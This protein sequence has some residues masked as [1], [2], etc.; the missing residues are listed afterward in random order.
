MT[1]KGIGDRLKK[2]PATELDVM[3]V[4]VREEGQACAQE[5]GDVRGADVS[6]EGQ[7]PKGEHLHL[8]SR[9]SPE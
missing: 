6:K 9:T 4:C 2:I 3:C 5:E 7:A 1:V 8:I